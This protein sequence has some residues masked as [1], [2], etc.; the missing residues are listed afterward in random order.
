M[1]K[2]S[3]DRSNER[4]KKIKCIKDSIKKN[5]DT[6]LNETNVVNMVKSEIDKYS[7]LSIPSS[8]DILDIDLIKEA[9]SV[10]SNNL[11]MMNQLVNNRHIIEN[12]FKILKIKFDDFNIR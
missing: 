11:T 12:R 10:K 1:N 6:I 3:E 5:S 9:D 2:T 4:K 8:S 7:F